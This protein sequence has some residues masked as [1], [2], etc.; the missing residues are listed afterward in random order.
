M[1]IRPGERHSRSG[2]REALQMGAGDI[3]MGSGALCLREAL[4]PEGE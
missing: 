2:E 4:W 3:H 1:G